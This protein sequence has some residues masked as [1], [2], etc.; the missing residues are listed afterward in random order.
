MLESEN[1]LIWDGKIYKNIGDGEKA[2]IILISKI[3]CTGVSFDKYY[4]KTLL[5]FGKIGCDRN[6][7][8]EWGGVA[9]F[10]PM[11]P[12]PP[13]PPLLNIVNVVALQTKS[14]G[15]REYYPFDIKYSEIN[16]YLVHLFITVVQLLYRQQY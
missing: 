16:S 5:N 8:V 7:L 1:L 10:S 11:P 12:P 4:R 14:E 15:W 13:T 2:K 9:K 6:L 3:Y